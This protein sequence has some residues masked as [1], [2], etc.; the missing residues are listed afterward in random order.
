[1]DAILGLFFASVQ[2]TKGEW[3]TSSGLHGI[4]HGLARVIIKLHGYDICADPAFEKCQQVLKNM[5][6]FTKKKEKEQ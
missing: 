3:Y 2:T 5:K 1:M 6:T 4:Y